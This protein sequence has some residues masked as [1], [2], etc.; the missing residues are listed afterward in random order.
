MQ[1]LASLLPDVYAPLQKNGYGLQG[2]Y[3][4]TL[5]E[6]FAAALADLIG[7]EAR[8]LI[9]GTRVAE[10]QALQPA[11][12]LFEW[13]EHQI[14][15]IQSDSRIPET[16]RQAVVLG[17]RGQGFFKQ[18]VMQIER[19]CRITC[20]TRVEHLR[21]RRNE[22]G[23]VLFLARVASQARVNVVGSGLHNCINRKSPGTG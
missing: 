15:Q 10:E 17:R 14:N 7:A 8:D 13:E 9:R 16:T 23:Q 21:A 5:S 1:V 11:I 20:V 6:L 4:T 12:G 2:V 19:A 18:R 22:G 3:L